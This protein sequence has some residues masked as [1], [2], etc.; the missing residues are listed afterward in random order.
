MNL[1]HMELRPSSAGKCPNSDSI[2]VAW[3]E[4][5]D[6]CA[7]SFPVAPLLLQRVDIRKFTNLRSLQRTSVG[8]EWNELSR[9]T[10]YQRRKRLIVARLL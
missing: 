3:K 5:Y 9:R 6:A 8:N 10:M 2:V 1:G 4:H 7:R